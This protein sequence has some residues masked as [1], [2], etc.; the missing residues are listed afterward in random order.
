MEDLGEV[1]VLAHPVAA[2]ADVDDMA[3]MQQPV[4]ERSGHD[5]VAQNLAPLLEAFIGGQH[6]G[7]ALIAPVDELEEEHGAG[8]TDRQSTDDVNH[9]KKSSKLHQNFADDVPRWPVT[10]RSDPI[11][12]EITA[13]CLTSA[14]S[15]RLLPCRD[16]Y[17]IL[18]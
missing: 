16:T 5:L 1:G 17:C 2:A 12:S 14:E 7:C 4:D 13:C 18:S 15:I 3:V 8:L 10:T 6:S 9:G 11:T